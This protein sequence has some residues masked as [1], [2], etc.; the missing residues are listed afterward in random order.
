MANNNLAMGYQGIQLPNPLDAYAKVMGIQHAQNQNQLAQYQMASAQRADAD[1]NK[2]RETLA[3]FSPDM[4]FEDQYNMLIKT[5]NMDAAR[6]FAESHAKVTKDQRE[7]DKNLR[8]GEKAQMDMVGKK[9]ELSRDFLSGIDP[10]A[11]TTPNTMM[12]WFKGALADPHIGPLMAKYGAN[13]TNLLGS[14]EQAI[15]T[16]GGMDKLVNGWR[17]GATEF[18]KLNKPHFAQAD[19][20]GTISQVQT[21]GLG[22]AP[23]ITP[24]ANKVATPGE[25]IRDETTRRGQDKAG[26]RL[27]GGNLT[28]EQNDALYGVNGAVTTGKLD[29]RRVN[30]R[31]ATILANAYM[32]NPNTDM[33]LLSSNAALMGNAPYMARAQTTELLPEI[34]TNVVDAGKKV[35]YSD[36]AFVGA[37]QKFA[38]GQMNDPDF[39][40]Y[41]AQRNDALLTIAGVMRGNGATDQAHRA[42]TEAASPTMSP[43]ALEAWMDAQ[44]KAL[45]PRLRNAQKVTRTPTPTPDA[46]AAGGLSPAEQSELDALRQRFGRK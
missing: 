9:L 14:I 28:P 1:Q 42:E 31:T 26:E 10:N 8:E 5:G 17:L 7:G 3:G 43:R 12:Q 38:N 33:N 24:I 36:A 40:N 4:K 30:S 39:V 34:L 37:L 45:A 15:K 25:L 35:N 27:A 20:G 22:G 29:P 2:L 23:I 19:D 18:A 13:E 21:P 32:L 46:P 41:M 16:P 11:P 6:K 44:T